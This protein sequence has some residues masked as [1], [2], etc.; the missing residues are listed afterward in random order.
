MTPC[1]PNLT[2]AVPLLKTTIAQS[3]LATLA[4][5]GI[6]ACSHAVMRVSPP[7]PN[8]FPANCMASVAGATPSRSRD[9]IRVVEDGPVESQDA[10][11][12]R[13]AAER[14]AFGLAYETLVKV[15]CQGTLVPGLAASWRNSGDA[16][17]FVLRKDARFWDGAP[18]LAGDVKS[19]WR[20][21]DSSLAERT[22]TDGDTLIRVAT[23]GFDPM[24]AVLAPS[25]AITK[26]APDHG[27]PIGTG[28]RWITDAAN[29]ADDAVL[30]PTTPGTAPR[31]TFAHGTGDARDALESHAD[32]VITR[33]RAALALA[34]TRPRFAILPM[35][36]NEEYVLI[37]PDPI[38]VDRD[39]LVAAVRV[40]ATPAGNE[41]CP[42]TTGRQAKLS[43]PHRVAY[44]RGD[45]TGE[46]LA[47]RLIG[48]GALGHGVFAVALSPVGWERAIESG[49][50]WAMIERRSAAT[51]CGPSWGQSTPLIAVRAS[52][53]LDRSLLPV[54]LNGDGAPRLGDAR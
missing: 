49:S 29:D 15:D 1:A 38:S 3:F 50:E 12:P 44:R 17:E 21:T 34:A 26:P 19:A 14:I 8:H 20:L 27:W 53:V 9:S 32:V 28:S 24:P 6:F 7:A 18:V 35:A 51:P 2:G 43:G 52:V 41:G 39:D 31:I 47:A 5:A 46:A 45:P 11:V 36:W 42:A 4:V 40:D 30:Q 13:S 33:D 16:M 23:S 10:P 48:S 22:T 54:R 37:A 25:A